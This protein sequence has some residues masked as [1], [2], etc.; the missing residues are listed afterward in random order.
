MIH[1]VSPRLYEWLMVRSM[2]A[3]LER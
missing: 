2:R 3:E 1:T